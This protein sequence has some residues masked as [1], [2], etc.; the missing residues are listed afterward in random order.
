VTGLPK[1]EIDCGACGYKTCQERVAARTR[2]GK[3]YSVP[4]CLHTI[5]DL[6]VALGSAVRVA[7]I[8]NIDNRVQYTVGA[9]AQTLRLL[10]ANMMIGVPLSVTGKNPHF[11]T[12]EA[13]A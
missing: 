2:E 6:G 11:D 10:G 5:I 1:I 13:A 8:L 4:S 7:G 3:D 12:M 9:A